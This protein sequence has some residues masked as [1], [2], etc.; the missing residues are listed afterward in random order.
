MSLVNRAVFD[1][2]TLISAVLRP[3]SVPR[4]AFISALGSHTLFVSPETLD[5]LEKVLLRPKFDAYA[6][7]AERG[8]F[9]ARYKQETTVLTPDAQSEQMAKGACRDA[10]DCKF[11][12]LAMACKA[13]V[14]VSSDDDLLS[15]KAWHGTQIVSPAVFFSRSVN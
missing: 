14:L 4:Q 8:T 11:L 3:L 13:G 6:S 15:L 7:T 10:N 1:T 9:F 5:E 2:S 12:A